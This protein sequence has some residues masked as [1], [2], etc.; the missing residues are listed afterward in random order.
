MF[1]DEPQTILHLPDNLKILARILMQINQI[2]SIA[3]RRIISEYSSVRKGWNPY[4]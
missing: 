1:S 4:L 2:K 3:T